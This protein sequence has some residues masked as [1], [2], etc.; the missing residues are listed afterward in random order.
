LIVV[1][2]TGCVLYRGLFALR[3]DAALLL[4]V[5]AGCVWVAV[6]ASGV[7]ATVAGILLAFATPVR[8]RAGVTRS[9]GEE[10][11][12][13]L[14]PLSAGVAVPVFA[15]AAAGVPLSALG[16]APSDRVAIAV[17]VALLFGK[18]VGILG[19]AR[20]ASAL[21]L[22][23][24]PPNVA[25]SDVVPVAVLG[26]VGYTVSLLISQLAFETAEAQ[27]RVAGSVLAASI[28]ASVTALTLLKRHSGGSE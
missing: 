23:A 1:A 21:R 18:F 22:G 4:A 14:H 3:L 27:E 10:L 11:E 9:R 15:I 26:G 24:L 16:D 13:R 28:I 6:H 17:F 7:H 2:A 25:W 12:H 19:G 5:V 20:L 8:P